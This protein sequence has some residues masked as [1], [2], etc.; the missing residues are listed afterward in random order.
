MLLKER[1]DST[2]EADPQAR[3]MEN[4]E[5]DETNRQEL[6]ERWRFVRREEDYYRGGVQGGRRE[7]AP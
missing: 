3:K 7:L 5:Q 6:R 2:E 4:G 1:I